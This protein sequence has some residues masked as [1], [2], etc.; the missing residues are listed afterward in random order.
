MTHMLRDMLSNTLQ[1]ALEG[2]DA[3]TKDRTAEAQDK[4]KSAQG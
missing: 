1:G 3:L 2:H 4:A